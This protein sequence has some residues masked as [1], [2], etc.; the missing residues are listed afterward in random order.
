LRET[1]E[2]HRI[3]GLFAVSAEVSEQRIG[4]RVVDVRVLP[5]VLKS[6][7]PA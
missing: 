2:A 1:E 6:T 3:E 5:P 7:W 4:E